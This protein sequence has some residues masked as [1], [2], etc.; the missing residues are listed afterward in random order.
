VGGHH[1]DWPFEYH[2]G[3]IRA[4]REAHPDI[5]IKAFT[6]A[7]IDT[8]RSA[9]RLSVDEILDRLIAAG[10]KRDARRGAEIFSTRVAKEL[11]YAA[12][13]GAA[14]ARDSRPRRTSAAFVQRDHAVG[15]IETYAGASST[16]ACS[17]EHR[18]EPRLLHSF[19]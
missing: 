17:G 9:G 13:A 18:T 19:A 1:P 8:L 3:Y 6:R 11:R 10:L 2:E 16:C 14:L 5:Q 7:E 4:I 15:H 12:S